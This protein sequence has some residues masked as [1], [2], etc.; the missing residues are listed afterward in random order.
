MLFFVIYIVLLDV[1]FFN[2]LS[3]K[4]NLKN[5][6]GKPTLKVAIFNYFYREQRLS[7]IIAHIL[8]GCSVFY[9]SLVKVYLINIIITKISKLS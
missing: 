9:T 4:S 5:K 3:F 1:F 2:F 8:I 7:A 6:Y